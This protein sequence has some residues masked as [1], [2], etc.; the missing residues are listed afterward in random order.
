MSKKTKET[1]KRNNRRLLVVGGSGELGRQIVAAAGAWEVHATFHTRPAPASAPGATWHP[2]D[3]VDRRAVHALVAQVS[4]AAVIHAA[5]SGHSQ[6]RAASDADFIA[7]IVDGGCHVAE[8]AAEAGARCI[9]LS[10]DLVFDGVQGNYAEEDPPSPIMLYGQAKADMERALL[11]ME[12]DLAIVRTS[13]ILTLEPMGKHVDWIVAA[14]R[15]G[16]R[17]TLFTDELRCPVWSDELATALLEL[18]SLDYRGLLHIAGPEVTNRYALGLALAAYFGLDGTS[19]VPGL[20]VES[21]LK[22]PVNSTLN[23]SRAYA[24][25]KTSIRG[26]SARLDNPMHF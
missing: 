15:R 2:L 9:V 19:L 24:L 20:S 8:A 14:H 3:I 18:T 7:S 21:G 23:S 1:A 22:R 5:V 4:P 12:T 10:T 26:V 11:A 6:A 17:R 25:L 13:L 16:E